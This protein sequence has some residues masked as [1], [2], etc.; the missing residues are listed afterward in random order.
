MPQTVGVA[1]FVQCLLCSTPRAKCTVRWF[2]IERGLKPGQRDDR[3]MALW[4][5]QTEDEAEF[6]HVHVYVDDTQ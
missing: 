5:R 4:V 6:W 2:S 1:Q 3:D